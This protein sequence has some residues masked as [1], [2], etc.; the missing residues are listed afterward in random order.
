M[1]EYIY[2]R[3][4]ISVNPTQLPISLATAKA[5]LRVDHSDDDTYITALIW[6]ASRTIEDYTKKALSDT[7]YKQTMDGFPK[8]YIE[9][10]IGHDVDLTIQNIQ[11]YREDGTLTIIEATRYNL[12]DSF[13][14]GRIYWVS[15]FDPPKQN[16]DKKQVIVN[17]RSGND[18]SNNALPYSVQQALLL[19]IGH[20]YENR[21][22][23]VNTMNRELPM[24][25]D[26]LLDGFKIYTA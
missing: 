16:K 23:V 2:N 19:L 12:D 8:K 24:G 13:N 20:Y 9:L 22:A 21:M 18:I 11:F 14:P 25:V 26:Y 15:D 6:S 7:E 10:L 5:H 17:F 1:E 3:L 4:Q